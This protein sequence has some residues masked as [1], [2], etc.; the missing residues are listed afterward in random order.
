MEARNEEP[1][2]ILPKTRSFE[3]SES[4]FIAQ[5]DLRCS[6][7][8]FALPAQQDKPW[9]KIPIPPLHEFK[10]QQPKRIELKNGIVSFPAG[11]SRTAV[12]RPARCSIPGGSRDEDRGQG[13]PGRHSMG[14]PGAPAA[15]PRWT[16][17]PWTICSKS[18]RRTLRPAA[19][20]IPPSLAWDSLKGDADQV[21]SLAMD[22]LLHPKFNAE[23]LAT[24]PAAGGHRHRP[25]Q[26]R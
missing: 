14:R 25:P 2:A 8:R 23:K 26:R 22:L 13:W 19:T 10:P 6:S 5:H 4:Q 17:M 9:E 1:V 11:G 15:P 12:R 18:R 3:I 21:F 20:T 16:A 24:G 7:L